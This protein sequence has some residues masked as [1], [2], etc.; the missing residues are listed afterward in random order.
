MLSLVALWDR[1][2][3]RCG[4]S[5]AASVHRLRKIALPVA[6]NRG[7]AINKADMSPP[8]PSRKSSDESGQGGP[9]LTTWQWISVIV[10]LL[11]GAVGLDQ[12]MQ[13]AVQ[14]FAE[15]NDREHTRI[16][17]EIRELSQNIPPEWFRREVQINQTAIQSIQGELRQ[18]QV[19]VAELGTALREMKV[20]VGIMVEKVSSND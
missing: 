1:M 14:V 9:L 7:P 20:Q 17:Q 3:K 19:K 11:G 8:S 10:I 15:A 6:L 13:T 18:L 2:R 12:R 5:V 4:C 16:R